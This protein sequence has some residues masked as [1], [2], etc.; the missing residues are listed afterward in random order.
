MRFRS[1]HDPPAR[2]APWVAIGAMLAMPVIAR[3]PEMTRLPALV[4]GVPLAMTGAA[5]ALARM[6]WTINKTAL[7]DGGP[8]LPDP[9]EL[10]SGPMRT[11]WFN[12][13]GYDR[14]LFLL[15]LA[16]IAELGLL[17]GGDAPHEAGLWLWCAAVYLIGAANYTRTPP[18]EP[19]GTGEN[20]NA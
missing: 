6:I 12:L 15:M 5:M 4:L 1:F 11:R 2:T 19:A 18:P 9:G 17:G 8:M 7:T 10:N 20:P 3:W 14:R 16:L 13:Y